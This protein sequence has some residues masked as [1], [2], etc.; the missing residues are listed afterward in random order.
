[1]K[2]S[3]QRQHNSKHNNVKDKQI[4]SL[5]LPNSHIDIKQ[6]LRE[7]L[8]AFAV[9]FALIIV[10]EILEEEISE[11]CGAR[12]SR[13]DQRGASRHGSQRGSVVISG[14]KVP[15]DKPRARGPAGEIESVIY[16]LLNRPDA[17]PESSLRRIMCGVSCRNYDS[18]ID[19]AAD[20]FGVERS[21]ISRAFV[22]ASGDQ[23]LSLAERRFDDERYPVV[24]IDGI[25][26]GCETLLVAM[27]IKSSGIKQLLGIRQGATENAEVCKDLLQSLIDRGLHTDK[28]ML[29]VIDGAKALKK[30]IISH[31][32]DYAF[33]QR[34]QV[35]KKRNVKG[36][37]SDAVWENLSQLMSAAYN[38][39]DYEKALEK[40]RRAAGWLERIN[41]S[42]A[43]SLREGMEE[44]LTVVKLGVPEELR[45]TVSSTNPIESALSTTRM[46]TGR[47]K[48]WQPGDM[49]LRWCTAGL[50]EA[51]KRFRRIRGYK[52]LYILENALQSAF[53]NKGLA[54]DK[55][56]A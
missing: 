34:C 21:S 20:G 43:E 41:P 6:M 14:Q 33:I 13:T 31:F 42:A 5:Q 38:E 40:L 1:M 51:E 27:G 46:I 55:Q 48:R 7:N 4:G 8:H 18:A 45:K 47:V 53:N 26:Y 3:K 16:S 10:K 15:I 32:G 23:L 17:M 50:M 2:Q 36:Y 35:H 12:Y 39:T 54:P 28:P 22:K 56:V 19:H 29:F 49:R 25:D 9:D 30:A 37:L 44:T 11:H 24:Y 52:Q